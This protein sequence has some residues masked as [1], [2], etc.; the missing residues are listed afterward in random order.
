MKFRSGALMGQFSGSLGS[1]TASR[2]RFGAYLR[3]RN[4]PVN[5]DSVYQQD[6]KGEFGIVSEAWANLTADQRKQW[7]TWASTHPITDKLG[8]SQNLDGHQAHQM[9]NVRLAHAGNGVLT[10][11][12]VSGPPAGLTTLSLTADV[13]AGSVALT[14]TATPVGANNKV[15]V[16]AAVV[17]SPG[18]AFV[19]NL[20][21]QVVISA[22]NQAS[23]YD[24]ESAVEGRFGALIVGQYLHVLVN[25][26]DT[27]TGLYASPLS[28]SSIVST[29]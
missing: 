16:W 2:N 18:R 8:Q 13:G 4:I 9:L 22:A 3:A 15:A 27:A 7:F 21:K 5:P 19:R 23:P 20:Y 14:Y 17:N 29:T 1:V 12:P 10:S 25:V 26:L 28:A 24:I 6:I 11:P